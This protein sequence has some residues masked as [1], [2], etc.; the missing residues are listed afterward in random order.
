MNQ[1]NQTL[2][3]NPDGDYLCVPDLNSQ[4][5]SVLL[6]LHRLLQCFS[7]FRYNL[8]LSY[9]YFVLEFLPISATSNTLYLIFLSWRN[10]R[11][12][13]L[14]LRFNF[15]P[16]KFS[17]C[18]IFLLFDTIS[19]ALILCSVMFSFLYNSMPCTVLEYLIASSTLSLTR[20]EVR[21][22]ENKLNT[23]Q[24]HWSKP[25]SIYTKLLQAQRNSCFS[26]NPPS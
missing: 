14:H 21:K 22:K 3:F 12:I 1:N 16:E 18:H 7:D 6:N 9:I 2:Y 5:C 25:Q 13:Y 23:W 19:V 17:V 26:C 20:G 24:T 11:R 4:A 8:V 15:F 10:S